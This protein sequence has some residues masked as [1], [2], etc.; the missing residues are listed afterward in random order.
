MS[1]AFLMIYLIWQYFC[2]LFSLNKHSFEMFTKIWIWK[3]SF[4]KR[5]NSKKSIKFLGRRKQF[6]P[7]FEVNARAYTQNTFLEVKK[8]TEKISG[9]KK[10]SNRISSIIIL[11]IT[12]TWFESPTS[13]ILRCQFHQH[14]TSPFFIRKFFKART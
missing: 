3:K 4:Y 14:F 10:G 6:D 11:G 5:R 13:K 2:Q 12:E 1:D 9:C 8:R 7:Y